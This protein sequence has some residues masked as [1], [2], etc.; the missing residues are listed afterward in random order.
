MKLGVRIDGR[1]GGFA[2]TAL[3]R[4]RDSAL[5]TVERDLRNG[6]SRRGRPDL[7]ATGAHADNEG[8]TR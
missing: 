2:A 8:A 3:Q 7:P 5:E 4:L 6:R 1:G